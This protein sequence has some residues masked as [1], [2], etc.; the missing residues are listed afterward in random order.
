[1]MSNIVAQILTEEDKADIQL[2]ANCR[3]YGAILAWQKSQPR[4]IPNWESL[5]K[6]RHAFLVN[7][8]QSGLQY[9]DFC[10]ALQQSILSDLATKRRRCG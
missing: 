3:Y 9:R 4:P 6:H 7:L 10:R 8:F 1:M 5:I 2:S